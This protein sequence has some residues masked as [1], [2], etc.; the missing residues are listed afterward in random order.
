MRV[1]DACHMRVRGT[2]IERPGPG[3]EDAARLHP[4]KRGLVLLLM[5]AACH[6]EQPRA[7]APVAKLPFGGACTTANDCADGR[8]FHKHVA[9]SD[10][11]AVEA[12][13]YCTLPCES[14]GDCPAPPT[15]GKCGGR[16]MCKRP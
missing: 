1:R 6:G 11:G 2:W 15:R 7:P 8:C 13:G 10:A 9:G 12:Q 3:I 5:L 4:V 14:D 16:R